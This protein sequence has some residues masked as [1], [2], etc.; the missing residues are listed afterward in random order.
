MAPAAALQEELQGVLQ[1]QDIIGKDLSEMT[2]PTNAQVPTIF[3]LLVGYFRQNDGVNMNP[4]E[5]FRKSSPQLEVSN[6]AIHLAVGNYGYITEVKNP[7]VVSNYMKWLLLEMK[8]P[9][10][11]FSQYNDYG[12]LIELENKDHSPSAQVMRIKELVG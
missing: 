4:E 1:T 10:I 7:H 8:D 9:L 3:S 12:R 5:L 6:L 2:R 11:P